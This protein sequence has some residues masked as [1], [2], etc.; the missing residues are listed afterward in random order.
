[1][2]ASERRNPA[3]ARGKAER[4][5]LAPIACDSHHAGGPAAITGEGLVHQPWHQPLAANSQQLW[6]ALTGT[7]VSG[8][9][10]GQ[11]INPARR[12]PWLIGPAGHFDTTKILCVC[13]CACAYM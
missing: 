13:V 10:G 8:Y 5:K 7:S 4:P 1:V 2:S 11:R 12:G 9:C 3:H 6:L